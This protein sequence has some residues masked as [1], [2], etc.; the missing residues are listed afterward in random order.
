[1][2]VGSN[3]TKGKYFWW[4]QEI[5]EGITFSIYFIITIFV[6]HGAEENNFSQITGAQAAWLSRVTMNHVSN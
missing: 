5:N 2:V 3:T 6:A 4:I 1:M